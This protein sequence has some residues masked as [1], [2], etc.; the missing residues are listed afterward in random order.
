MLGFQEILIIVLVIG[1][2]VAFRPLFSKKAPARR[3]VRPMNRIG[4]KWRLALA[5]SIVYP[6]AVAAYIRPWKSDPFDFYY[7]GIAPVVLAWLVCW[8]VMGFKKRF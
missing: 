4:G 1:G 3:P 8:T 6:A 5:A 7:V 2:I